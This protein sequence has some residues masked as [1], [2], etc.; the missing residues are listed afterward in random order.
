[1]LSVYGGSALDIGNMTAVS[2]NEIISIGMHT[3]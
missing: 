2:C 1:M 3:S